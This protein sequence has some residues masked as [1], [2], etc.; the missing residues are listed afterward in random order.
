M[1]AVLIGQLGSYATE[2]AD[3]LG[4]G[5]TSAR[6]SLCS[7]WTNSTCNFGKRA[8]FNQSTG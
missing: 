2:Q 5:D 3:W 4:L 7:D 6:D 8:Q 1:T